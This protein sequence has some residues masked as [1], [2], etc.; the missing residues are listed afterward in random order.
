ML[1]IMDASLTLA[2]AIESVLH[3]GE[4]ERRVDRHPVEFLCRRVA[5][6]EAAYRAVDV[7]AFSHP[8]QL[9]LWVISAHKL[10]TNRL[11]H[12]AFEQ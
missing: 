5:D 12:V 4:V 6:D 1:I 10:S 3:L 7:A 2:D 8:F 11:G 9:F